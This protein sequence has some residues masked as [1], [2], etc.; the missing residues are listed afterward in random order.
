MSN[1]SL[2]KLAKAHKSKP[3]GL[4][5]WES[6]K[7]EVYIGISNDSVTKRLRQHVKNYEAANIQCFRY[8][9]NAGT[10]EKLREIERELIHD[11]LAAGFTVFNRE[12]SAIIY[13]DSVFDE[14]ISVARQREWF[15]DPVAVNATQPARK[16]DSASATARATKQFQK[17]RN[18]PS[19]SGV[20]DALSL[21]LA[22]CTPFPV[23]TES[24]YWSLTC[25]PGW[26]KHRLVTLNMGYLEMFWATDLGSNR[27]EISVG[28]DY[29]FL[30]R[31][32]A[33]LKLHRLGVKKTGPA[34]AA[35]GPNEEVLRFRSV[36]S[37]IAVMK[38]SPEVRLAV[39]RFALD[40][41]RKGRV[42]GRFRDAHNCLLAEEA[43]RKMNERKTSEFRAVAGPVHVVPPGS[44]LAV[45]KRKLPRR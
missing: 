5:M 41:M 42:S 37:F 31:K 26:S 28:A 6:A 20:V 10:R 24:E 33:W 9:A 13:G 19:A 3:V 23:E 40:R 4:Y 35:G 39:A 1:S 8:R 32:L 30:P 27:T 43:L 29:Q 16:D 18:L 7:H 11:A 21:Y 17:F 12:H 45:S 34:H 14:D 25:L 22:A 2:L 36:D 44:G 15:A 38:T